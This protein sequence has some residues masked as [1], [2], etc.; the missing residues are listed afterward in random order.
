MERKGSQSLNRFLIRVKIIRNSVFFVVFTVKGVAQ[1][2]NRKY[3]MPMGGEEFPA[4]RKC[5]VVT[6]QVS[7][8]VTHSKAF[9]D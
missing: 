3:N 8:V 7:H 5:L 6:V 1:N 9:W 4:C 2:I